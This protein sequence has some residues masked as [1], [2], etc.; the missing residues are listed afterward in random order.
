VKLA[1]TGSDFTRANAGDFLRGHGKVTDA[2]GTP[3][4]DNTT[5]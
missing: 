2:T 4:A 1:E 3:L 5:S